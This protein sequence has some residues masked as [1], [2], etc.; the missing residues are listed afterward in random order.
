MSVWKAVLHS[1]HVQPRHAIRANTVEGRHFFSLG[2]ERG[3][4]GDARARDRS[5]KTKRERGLK[6]KRKEEEWV[7]LFVVE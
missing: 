6:G 4:M 5:V 7:V 3:E 1:A 2:E